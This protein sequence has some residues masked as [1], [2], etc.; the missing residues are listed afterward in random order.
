MKLGA[1]FTEVTVTVNV[2]VLVS[3]PPALSF[4]VT[5]IVTGVPDVNWSKFGVN[6]RTA[7]GWPLTYVT[8]GFGII[9]APAGFEVAVTVRI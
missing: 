1:S 3:K 8:T 4:A 7:V 2:C 9:S 6:F 5:V